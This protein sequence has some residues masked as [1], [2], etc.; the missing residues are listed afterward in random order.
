M[1]LRKIDALSAEVSRLTSVNATLEAELA[2]AQGGTEQLRVL[3][4]LRVRD[5][6]KLEFD[7]RQSRARLRK[8][9]SR[10]RPNT[11]PS[12]PSFADPEQGFRFLVLSQWASRFPAAEQKDRPLVEYRLGPRF[13]SSLTALEGIKDEKVAAV[14]VEIVTGVAP[15]VAGREVHQ[16][17]TG[18][19]GGAPVRIRP[20]GAVAW[21]A[22]LQVSS[23]S[24]RR[25]HYWVLPDHVIEFACVATH[26]SF[27]I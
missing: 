14:V 10:V 8:A 22:S 24:A 23:P 6:A 3:L 18:S 26:D 13:L 20:D 7:V 27:D 4:D 19:G 17:R 11:A 21:R 15:K 16:L 1:L 25:I 2:A 12:A 9:G 5:A